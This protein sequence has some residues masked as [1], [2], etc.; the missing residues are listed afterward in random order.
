[1]RAFYGIVARELQRLHR[2]RGRILS[3]LARPLIWLFI[4]GSGVGAIAAGVEPAAYRRFMLPGVTG[5]VI[6]F[7]AMFGALSMAHDREFG[8][9]R[10]L[11]IAPVRRVTIVLGKVV[12]SAL[13]AFLQAAVLLLLLPVLDLQPGVVRL[14]SLVGAMALTAVALSALG[15]LLASRVAS[16]ENFSGVVNFVVFPMFFLSGALY[17][18]ESLPEVLRGLTVVNPLTYGVD[19]MK[20]ALFPAAGRFGAELPLATDIAVLV[21]TFAACL[22]QIGRA[23]V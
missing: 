22:G 12:S 21:G 9:I 18:V 11:L 7:S 6:L 15:M 10:L 3:G 23:H 16:L 8:V 4:V 5:M 14:T 17:P 13:V 20:H 19:L 1:M 2:Q